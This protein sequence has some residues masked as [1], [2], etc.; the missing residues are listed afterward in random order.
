[1]KSNEEKEKNNEDRLKQFFVELDQYTQSDNWDKGIKV[2]N[3]ILNVAPNDIIGVHSMIVCLMENQKWK[4]ALSFLNLRRQLFDGSQYYYIHF[5]ESYCHY[6]LESYEKSLESLEEL[7]RKKLELFI[8][9]KPEQQSEE[10]DQKLSIL[11]SKKN[12]IFDKNEKELLAQVYY[13]LGRYEDS[14]EIYKSLLSLNQNDDYG[15]ERYTNYLAVQCQNELKK[16]ANELESGKHL[17]NSHEQM[18]EK[19]NE[20]K[21]VL[22]EI[23]SNYKKYPVNHDLLFNLA[24]CCLSLEN[25]EKSKKFL[26]EAKEE[27]LIFMKEQYDEDD[28]EFGE[29]LKK[30]MFSIDLQLNYIEQFEMKSITDRK[31]YQE[32]KKQLIGNYKSLLEM[33]QK[34]STFNSIISNNIMTLNKDQSVFDSKKRLRTALLPSKKFGSFHKYHIG[35]NELIF[36]LIN[37]KNEDFTK[38]IQSFHQKYQSNTFV[39]F[40]HYFIAK[41]DGTD[42]EQMEKSFQKNIDR[43]INNGSI[44]KN[45]DIMRILLFLIE[46]QSNLQ[47]FINTKSK[48]WLSVTYEKIMNLLKNNSYSTNL[49]GIIS[50]ILEL[51]EGVN[52]IDFCVELCRKI[53]EKFSSSIEFGDFVEWKLSKYYMM[54]NKNNEAVNSLKYLLS[55]NEN[56]VHIIAGLIDALW[57]GGHMDEVEEL[58]LKIPS[59]HDVIMTDDQDGMSAQEIDEQFTITILRR[60][61]MADAAAAVKAAQEK[62]K[63]MEKQ[64]REDEERLSRKRERNKLRRKRRVKKPKNFL[65]IPI[66]QLDAERWLPLKERSYFRGKRRRKNDK[67]QSQLAKGTQGTT[68]L[69]YEDNL[70]YQSGSRLPQNGGQNAGGETIDMELKTGRKAA[71]N[72]YQRVKGRRVRRGKR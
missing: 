40:A 47:R 69:A 27:C 31:Q 60:Q 59:E 37:S 39:V 14:L 4:D 2:C 20:K 22:N 46:Y 49:L 53:K 64:H 42:I 44:S 11:K 19:E 1:M 9:T 23:K 55:K 29:E 5:N 66:E 61:Q 8:S 34:D 72:R 12:S 26:K 45:E 13:R 63:E 36:H 51:C 25:L 30:E 41:R 17:I 7:E 32:K 50:S 56:N 3:K 65:S 16:S 52:E 21:R 33:K 68:N 57:R 48:D 70:N 18:E 15:I 35:R 62:K 24:T 6:R 38:I 71:G 54:L 28:E 58:S 67:K 10:Y 43:I